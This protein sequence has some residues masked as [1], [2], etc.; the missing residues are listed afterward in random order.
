VHI[1]FTSMLTGGWRSANWV[2]CTYVITTSD[3]GDSRRYVAR[4]ALR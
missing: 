4:P 2:G 3:E 1:V